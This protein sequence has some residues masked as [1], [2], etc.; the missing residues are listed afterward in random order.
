M[1]RPARPP[2]ECVEDAAWSARCRT[3][4]RERPPLQPVRLRRRE[5]DTAE[6]IA[7]AAHASPARDTPAARAEDAQAQDRVPG[8]RDPVTV[9]AGP[10][11]LA[12]ERAPSHGGT[13]LE[14]SVRVLQR[15]DSLA[16]QL[17]G[18]HVLAAVLRAAPARTQI[19]ASARAAGA[20]AGP[21]ARQAVRGGRRRTGHSVSEVQMRRLDLRDVRRRAGDVVSDVPDGNGRAAPQGG[22]VTR[23][24]DERAR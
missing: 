14:P 18:A 8:R 16:P 3:A 23:R 9:P 4:T 22:R 7:L 24:C 1:T 17:A 5:A 10:E 19:G 15:G 6:A 21:G 11:I 2:C 20:A 12:G 13:G